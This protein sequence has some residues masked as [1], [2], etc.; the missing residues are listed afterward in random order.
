[1]DV[2]VCGAGPGGAELITDQVAK[3]IEQA[4][5]VF[6]SKHLE[7]FCGRLTNNY[8]IK[9]IGET[10]AYIDLEKD[11]DITLV[12]VAS[13]DTG[14]YSIA[15]TIK[16][17]AP[18]VVKVEF[19][20]GI[21]S[22]QYFA[23]KCGHGYENM[24]LISLHGRDGSLVPYVSYNFSVFALTGGDKSVAD[25]IEELCKYGLEDTTV[26]VGERLSMEGEKITIGRAGELLGEDFDPLAVMIVDNHDYRDFNEVLRDKDFIRGKVPMTK[27]AVRELSLAALNIKPK[28]VVYDIGAGTGAMT[29]ALA[30]KA[31]E[32]FVFAI[33]KNEEGIELLHKNM[34]KLGIHNI[35]I[36]QGTAPDG[37]RDFPVPDKAFIGGT[38]GNMEDIL[39]VILEKNPNAEILITAVT[40]ESLTEAFLL[41]S[42][43]GMEVTSRCVNVA[44]AHI[45]G[46]YH[47]MKAENPVYLIGGSVRDEAENS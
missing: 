42:N 27:E 5:V 15:S 14:F 37:M 11:K 35:S 36:I 28:D 41:L 9:T 38:T 13:G 16:R 3:T 6:T 10:L 23:A 7:D 21:S 18:D 40:M 31:N 20:P 2:I 32:S 8:K 1:M 19:L 45:L 12:V 4:D 29:C 44:D 17:K 39:D 33:E 22:M 46:R 47:L 34:D 26:F 43:K 24:K 25:N 30:Q